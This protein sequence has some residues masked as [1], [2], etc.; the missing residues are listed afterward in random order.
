MHNIH[1]LH[2]V[3]TFRALWLARTISFWGDTV[4]ATALV[5]YMYG[6]D[7]SGTTLSLVLLAQALPRVFGP[8]AGSLADRI[9]Q[10]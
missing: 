1:L 4:A 5:L 10:R 9:D 8:L 6:I 2:R 3:P 7:G